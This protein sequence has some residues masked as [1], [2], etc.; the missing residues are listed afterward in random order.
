MRV[1]GLEH[2]SA[3]VSKQIAEAAERDGLAIRSDVPEP[4]PSFRFPGFATAFTRSVRA[5]VRPE[6]QWV[7]VD[8]PVL[9]I[10]DEA[11][12]RAFARGIVAAEIRI[13]ET[14][15][16]DPRFTAQLPPYRRHSALAENLPFVEDVDHVRAGYGLVLGLDAS[17]EDVRYPFVLN[18]DVMRLLFDDDTVKAVQSDVGKFQTRASEKFG[19]PFS[20]MFS[21]PGVRAAVTLAAGKPA[22]VALPHLRNVVEKQRGGWPHDVMERGLL[23]RETPTD[24]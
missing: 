20:G 16:H 18:V 1:L 19:G 10:N 22:G 7:D 11:N 2:A 4:L 5:V 17:A 12:P 9:P 6:A 15:G 14:Q 24:G 3:A 23:P 13:R 21:Q 8:L